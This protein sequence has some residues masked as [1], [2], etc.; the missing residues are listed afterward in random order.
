MK[1]VA[2]LI[3]IGLIAWLMWQ[4]K[5]IPKGAFFNKKPILFESQKVKWLVAYFCATLLVV[6]AANL[7]AI[8]NILVAAGR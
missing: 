1:V 6:L 7:R 8:V 5:P 2:W 3:F 4:R